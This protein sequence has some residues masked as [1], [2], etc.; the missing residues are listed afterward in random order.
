MFACDICNKSYTTKSG[1]GLHKMYHGPKAEELK[2]M[3]KALSTQFSVNKGK[4]KAELPYLARPNQIGKKFGSSLTGHS[5]ET[6]KKISEKLKGNR[7]GNHRGDR[8]SSYNGIRMDSL[9]EV[10]TAKYLDDN[11]INWKYNEKGFKLSNGNYYFPDFFIYENDLFIKLI[12][13]KG[14]FRPENKEKFEMFLKEYPETE[15]ELWQQD[16]L[17]ELNIVNRSGYL[18]DKSLIPTSK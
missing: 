7:N 9:W 6:K 10:G 17:M 1:L 16:K 13:V 11:K 18:K 3:R 5:A 2:A 14:Y 8:Q 15:V 12:E 4:T